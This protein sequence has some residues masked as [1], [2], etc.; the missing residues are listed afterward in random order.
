VIRQLI[1][2]LCSIITK[3]FQAIPG[4]SASGKAAVL[5]DFLL[6]FCFYYACIIIATFSVCLSITQIYKLHQF[7]K[8]NA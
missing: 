2:D 3:G 8:N 1:P 6:L 5:I 4:S 7:N